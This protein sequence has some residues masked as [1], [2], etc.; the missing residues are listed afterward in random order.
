MTIEESK[1]MWNLE[2]DNINQEHLTKA[3]KD[4]YKVVDEKIQAGELL[5]ETFAQD[6]MDAITTIIVKNGKEGVEQ[7]RTEQVDSISNELLSKYEKCVETEPIEGDLGIS[8]DSTE[9]QD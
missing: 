5:Y 2:K 8:V 9:V 7:N 1:I 4:L 3:M 6:M